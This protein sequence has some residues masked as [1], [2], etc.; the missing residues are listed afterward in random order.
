MNERQ[1]IAEDE[2]SRARRSRQRTEYRDD[3]HAV[4]DRRE[5]ASTFHGYRIE[6]P[7]FLGIEGL[8]R[9]SVVVTAQQS[10]DQRSRKVQRM[11]LEK[12]RR[13]EMQEL[14]REQQEDTRTV[15]RRLRERRAESMVRVL[16]TRDL[17]SDCDLPVPAAAATTTATYCTYEQLTTSG[18]AGGIFVQSSPALLE[19]GAGNQSERACPDQD[20][21]FQDREA[22]IPR[23]EKLELAR[24]QK[25]LLSRAAAPRP[26]FLATLKLEDQR[27]SVDDQPPQLVDSDARSM[28][29]QLSDLELSTVTSDQRKRRTH[30]NDRDDDDSETPE[31]CDNRDAVRAAK[32]QRELFAKSDFGGKCFGGGFAVKRNALGDGVGDSNVASTG[33]LDAVLNTQAIRAESMAHRAPAARR[34]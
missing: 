32:L 33:P 15:E 2:R 21:I 4:N 29:C 19:I 30:A 3:Q 16:N 14:L 13:K 31:V 28:A 22:A 7:Q 34:R 23:R 27:I 9:T 25:L 12:R 26:S 10:E 8:A 20:A 6:N 24:Q 1:L 11:K 5:E 17:A 18:S